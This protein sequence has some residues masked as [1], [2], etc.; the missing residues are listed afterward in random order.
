M[1]IQRGPSPFETRASA[2]LRVTG[3]KRSCSM[4][5]MVRRT[6]PDLSLRIEPQIFADLRAALVL[7]KHDDAV[8]AHIGVD[9]VETQFGQKLQ[10][11]A[12]V[13]P[14]LVLAAE[15]AAGVETERLDAVRSHFR[16]LGVKREDALEVVRV[17]GCDPLRP[18]AA[19]SAAT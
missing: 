15:R 8:R 7:V 13:H 18:S 11:F 16:V 17:P 5:E 1:R 3:R 19:R 4:R 9:Q 10:R 12:P 2:L 6:L 14:K